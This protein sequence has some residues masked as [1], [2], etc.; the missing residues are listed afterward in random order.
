ME[1][2]DRLSGFVRRIP[3]WLL[4]VLGSLSACVILCSGLNFY[5][6]R[7]EYVELDI[8]PPNGKEWY[9]TQKSVQTWDDNGA[10]F[11]IWRRQITL[12]QPC[13][14]SG[15]RWDWEAI[16]GYFDKWFF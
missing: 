6:G 13:C 9:Y 1:H 10:T 14:D 8:A 7:P 16:I 3:K 12:F 5:M 11:F 2:I 15:I 4:I